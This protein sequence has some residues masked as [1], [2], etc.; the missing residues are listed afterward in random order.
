MLSKRQPV[1]QRSALTSPPNTL[2]PPHSCA[3]APECNAIDEVDVPTYDSLGC[4][5]YPPQITVGDSAGGA[6]L[7]AQWFTSSEQLDRYLQSTVQC[8]DDCVLQPTCDIYVQ[9]TDE[10]D[11]PLCGNTLVTVTSSDWCVLVRRRAGSAAAG[12]PPPT[13][14]PNSLLTIPPPPSPAGSAAPT[15][16]PLP[17]PSWCATTM[18]RPP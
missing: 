8:Q 16:T 6:A 13:D 7:P 15:R 12:Y 14:L 17:R 9:Y 3:S 11:A 4:D 18:R 10:L 2:P 1:Q 5:L